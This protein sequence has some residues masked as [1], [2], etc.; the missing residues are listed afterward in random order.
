MRFALRTDFT[1]QFESEAPDGEFAFSLSI[2][3]SGP[4]MSGC[5]TDGQHTAFEMKARTITHVDH[6]DDAEWNEARP[7]DDYGERL[8]STW[9]TQQSACPPKIKPCCSVCTPRAISSR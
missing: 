4:A 8:P 2:A 9:N 5:N 3:V 1:E 6:S 7:T